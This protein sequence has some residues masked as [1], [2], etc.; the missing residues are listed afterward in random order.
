MI[1]LCLIILIIAAL[2]IILLALAGIVVVAWPVLLVL[3]IGLVI[4]I[5]VLKLIFR[6]KK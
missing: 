1:T 3:G 5:C 2:A 6:R 4:D